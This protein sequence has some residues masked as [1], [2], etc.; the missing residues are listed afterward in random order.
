MPLR[1]YRLARG[2][3]M[4]I[5]PGIAELTKTDI[6]QLQNLEE[7]IGVVMVAYER[8]PMLSDLSKSELKALK[9]TEKQMGMTLVAFRKE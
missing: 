1:G 4:E 7:K 8:L 6:R 2:E 5:R 3:M 9:E